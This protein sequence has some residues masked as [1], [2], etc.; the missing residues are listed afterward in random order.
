MGRLRAAGE[1]RMRRRIPW[2]AIVGMV[3]A[4]ILWAALVAHEMG[5]F[6]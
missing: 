3:V 6:K 5:A 4:L 2:K 1:E